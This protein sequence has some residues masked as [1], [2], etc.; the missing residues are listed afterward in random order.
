MRYITF[1]LYVLFF[2]MNQTATKETQ[3]N[4]WINNSSDPLSNLYPS[5]IHVFGMLHRSAEHAF[6]FRKAQLMKNVYIMSHI[7]ATNCPLIARS[8]GEQ[9]DTN[10]EWLAVRRKIMNMILRAKL[11]QDLEYQKALANLP[12]N[13]TICDDSQH[14]FWGGHGYNVIGQIHK[15]M[16]SKVWA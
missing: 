9:V 15:H 13:V 1:M 4:I 3:T 14:Y 8:L 2:Q 16:K 5:P 12:D 7:L 11:D 6:Q 10:R